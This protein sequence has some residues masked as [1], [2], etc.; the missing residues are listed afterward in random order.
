MRVELTKSQSLTRLMRSIDK[1]NRSNEALLTRAAAMATG[2]SQDQ[3]RKKLSKRPTVP[4]RTGRPTTKGGFSKLIRWQKD[5][6]FVQ[7]QQATLEEAAPYW[8]IQEIGTG[9]EAV[10]RSG[11]PGERSSLLGAPDMSGLAVSVKSQKGREISPSLTW[12][13]VTGS[14]AQQQFEYDVNL[15]DKRNQQLMSYRDVMNAPLK[16]DLEPMR[17]GQEIE[18]KHFIQRGGSIA[19][20]EYRASLLSLARE[21]LRKQ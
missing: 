9:E 21:T 1:F 14:G 13:E 16:Q 6:G 11:S 3:F 20:Q 5:Q 7:F 18:G 4:E 15:P 8:L 17:I 12:A 19:N 10:I 2:V